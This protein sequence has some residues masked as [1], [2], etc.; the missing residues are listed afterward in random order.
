M[1]LAGVAVL[2]NT[3][4]QEKQRPLFQAQEQQAIIYGPHLKVA[5]KVLSLCGLMYLAN[6]VVSAVLLFPFVCVSYVFSLIFDKKRRRLTDF[7]VSLWARFAMMLC[8]Y[9]PKIEGKENLPSDS[10]GVLYLAN[11]TSYLDI[12]TLSAFLNRG[13]KYVSKI[14]VLDIPIIGWAMQMAGH[15]A[16]RRNNRDSQVKTVTDTIHALKNGNSVCMFPEGTRTKTGRLNTFKKGSFVIAK[17]AGARIVP[18]S[19]CNVTK[20]FPIWA[21]MPLA[22][23]T[24]IIIKIHPPIDPEGLEE[25]ELFQQTYCAI[26]A[27][28]PECQRS[29]QSE[30]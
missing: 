6:I 14:E 27:G 11:H 25:S 16:V 15:I 24:D 13:F 4:P 22:C 21:W 28:L 1:T 26:E 23:P 30:K 2:P 8:L 12:L 19:L 17:K 29:L 20:W 10:E 3:Q 18:I 5:N 7:L 9:H